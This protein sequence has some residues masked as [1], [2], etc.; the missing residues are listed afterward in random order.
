MLDPVTIDGKIYVDGGVVNNFPVKEVKDMGADIIIGVNLG[1]GLQKRDDLNSA[2][3]ILSQI[4]T[5]SIVKK[6]DEQKKT[7]RFVN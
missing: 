1:D 5:M 7:S 4:M 6:T 2:I 3:D